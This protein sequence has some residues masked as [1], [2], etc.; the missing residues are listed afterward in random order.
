LCVDVPSEDDPTEEHEEDTATDEPLLIRALFEDRSHEE[1][2]AEEEGEHPTHEAPASIASPGRGTGMDPFLVL[3]PGFLVQLE[4]FGAQ[5]QVLVQDVPQQ[6]GILD[7]FEESDLEVGLDPG[8]LG[9]PIGLDDHLDDLV[10]D[11]R[12]DQGSEEADAH[13]PCSLLRDSVPRE[14]VQK[15]RAT[16]PE[17]ED[18]QK[19]QLQLTA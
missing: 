2:H 4:A 19:R 15:R 11:D 18:F 5:I 8:E 3:V 14:T 12:Q 10:D 13:D 7:L 1:P 17:E 6:F 16:Q 9:I